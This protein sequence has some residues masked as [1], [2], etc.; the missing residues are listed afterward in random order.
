MGEIAA[1]SKEQSQGIEQLNGA[2]TQMEKITQNNAANAEEAASASRELADQAQG[3]DGMVGE[4]VAIAGISEE[5][6]ARRQSPHRTL[7]T[8]P[9][10][11][12]IPF[13]RPALREPV[14]VHSRTHSRSPDEVIPLDGDDGF[15]E[16]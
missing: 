12:R 14:R 9:S 6:V 8:G 10:S 5:Q 4:L 11:A 1:A 7:H 15:E 13:A 16:F 2:V 3:L